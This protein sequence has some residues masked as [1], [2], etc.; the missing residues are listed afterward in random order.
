MRLILLESSSQ[1]KAKSVASHERIQGKGIG[2]R[3]ILLQSLE[4]PA[5]VEYQ[6]T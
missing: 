1:D 3:R 4:A 2:S 6:W 5:V